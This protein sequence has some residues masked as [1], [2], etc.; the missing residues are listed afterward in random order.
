MRPAF[1]LWN[2]AA[3]DQS[4]FAVLTLDEPFYL[5]LAQPETGTDLSVRFS[6]GLSPEHF[7]AESFYFR[8]L[9]GHNSTSC[10][11]FYS[12]TG[13]AFLALSVFK[14]IVQCDLVVSKVIR[15]GEKF[16]LCLGVQFVVTAQ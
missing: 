16:L 6:C 14:G 15:K 13:G 7:F 4:P 2:I 10:C 3:G 11:N 12:T 9:P 1:R 8:I 5:L